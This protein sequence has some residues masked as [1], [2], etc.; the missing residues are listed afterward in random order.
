VVDDC[1][2]AAGLKIRIEHTEYIGRKKTTTFA[3][4]KAAGE[5]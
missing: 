5:Q 4:S 2:S 3:G 1:E